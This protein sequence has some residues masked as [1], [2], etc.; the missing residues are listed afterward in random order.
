MFRTCVGY[1]FRGS[2]LGPHRYPGIKRTPRCPLSHTMED[3][4][5]FGRDTDYVL[6]IFR[7]SWISCIFVETAGKSPTNMMRR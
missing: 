5:L 6:S 3:E 1:W 2:S 7:S 4:E